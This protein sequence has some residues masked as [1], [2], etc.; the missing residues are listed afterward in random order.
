MVEPVTPRL[1][2]PPLL[3]GNET[4]GGEYG[5]PLTCGPLQPVGA[6]IGAPLAEVEGTTPPTPVP[7]VPALPPPVPGA[8]PPTGV[9]GLPPSPEPSLAVV[10]VTRCGAS[11]GTN[12]AIST[13]ATNRH[14]SGP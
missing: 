11:V 8:T 5:S 10:T 9:V 13:N 1:V 2:A 12:A 3:P 14:A 4:H 7:P 6:V